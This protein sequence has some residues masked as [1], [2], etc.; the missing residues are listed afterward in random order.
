M[1]LTN[2]TTHQLALELLALPDLPVV[3]YYDTDT[4]VGY[5]EVEFEQREVSIDTDGDPTPWAT[6][7]VGTA[8]MVVFK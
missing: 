7:T 5:V 3:K 1:K 2:K 4:S 8:S 6:D